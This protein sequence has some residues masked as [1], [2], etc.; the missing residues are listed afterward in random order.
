VGTPDAQIRPLH[1][2]ERDALV[3][4]L[5]GWELPDGWRGRA[6]EFFRRYLDHDPTFEPRNV[7][8]AERAGRLVACAQIFPRELRV[9]A[10]DALARVSVGGIGSVFTRPEAR[11]GGVASAVLERA[12]AEM[13]A[14]GMALSVLFAE[15]HDFYGRLG[16]QLADTLRAVGGAWEVF[17]FAS[18]AEACR[19][20]SAGAVA[21][22]RIVVF[23]SFH[24]VAE[25]LV[26]GVL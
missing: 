7:V 12:I 19:A 13:R 15:L 25:A 18:V 16:W 26:A 14:R 2:D 4:L 22:D 17:P 8:V 20:A 3:A 5:D 10:G 21:G 1:S 24:T 6:S 9:R 11:G 23:G